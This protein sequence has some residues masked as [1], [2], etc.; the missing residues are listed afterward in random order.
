MLGNRTAGRV[1]ELNQSRSRHR[2]DVKATGPRSLVQELSCSD[3]D[4]RNVRQSA[5]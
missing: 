2:R 5:V 4:R 1:A 3:Q